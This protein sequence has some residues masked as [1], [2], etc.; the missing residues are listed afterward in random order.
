[1]LEGA[2]LTRGL[3]PQKGR[4][5]MDEAL[6]HT[7][8]D[9]PGQGGQTKIPDWSLPTHPREVNDEYVRHLQY[10]SVLKLSKLYIRLLNVIQAW[11]DPVSIIQT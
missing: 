10:N 4:V 1:M 11:R 8:K 6:G 9:Q 2:F 7:Q 3:P 5:N